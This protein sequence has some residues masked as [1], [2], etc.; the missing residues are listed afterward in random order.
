ME[1][2]NIDGLTKPKLKAKYL[3][4]VKVNTQLEEENK[5]LVKQLQAK[6]NS[7]VALVEKLQEHVKCPVCLEV[8]TSGPI[9]SCPRGHLVCQACFQGLK[10]VCP[11][12]RSRMANTVSLL[13]NTVI[14]N[15]EHRC[16]FETE[17]CK[18][19]SGASEVEE[20]RR[21]CNFRPIDCPSYYCKSKVPF[22]NLVDHILNKCKNSFAKTSGGKHRRV[23]DKGEACKSFGL[24]DFPKDLSDHFCLERQVFLFEPSP[25]SLALE[26]LYPDAGHRGRMRE[27]DC[28]HHCGR[29]DW[30]TL[31]QVQQQSF[32][33][34][35]V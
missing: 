4:L 10:N 21:I 22:D 11:L 20:H 12:C 30:A 5:L 16:K 1:N 29:A 25:R 9:W 18:A 24:W 33:C 32:P 26:F 23:V 6:S 3:T 19:M 13:A 15:I 28:G 14:K 2:N 31:C 35:D 8:P 7:L 27:S 34:R 17:G